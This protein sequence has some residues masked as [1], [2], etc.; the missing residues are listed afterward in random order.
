MAGF[1]DRLMLRRMQARW[2]QV[3]DTAGEMEAGALR[4]WRGRARAMRRDVDRALYVSEQRLGRIASALPRQ[5]LGTDWAWRP[6][7]WTG[8]VPGV[9]VQATR[10][11]ISPDVALFHDCKLPEVT[12][13]Q[14]C[15][16][17]D[18]DRAPFALTIESF[19]FDGSFLSLAIDLPEAAVA[20]LQLRHLIRVE[21][22]VEVERPTEIFA[23]LNVQNG[24]NTEQLVREMP[25]EAGARVVEFDLTYSKIDDKRVAKIWLDLIFS[26]PAMTRISL[27]DVTVSRRPRAEL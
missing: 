2:A 17:A 4:A 6:D 13:R 1:L 11:A 3:A 16:G 15:N 22:V 5:P 8:P 10:T 20:G 27:R 25:G 19:A 9:V 12:V 23:R 14:S 24:P 7:V 26:R 21:A 18:R